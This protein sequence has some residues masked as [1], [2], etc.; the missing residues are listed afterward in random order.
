MLDAGF[1]DETLSVRPDALESGVWSLEFGRSFTVLSG[2]RFARES[3]R[4]VCPR[5]GSCSGSGSG[6]GSSSSSSSSGLVGFGLQAVCYGVCTVDRV[7]CTVAETVGGSVG[8]MDQ[9]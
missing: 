6:S 7:P 9:N 3:V 1:P 4:D 2:S 8:P 5:S